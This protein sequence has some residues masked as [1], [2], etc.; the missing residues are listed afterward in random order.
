[1]IFHGKTFTSKVSL[2]E[3]CAAIAKY[4]FVASPYPVII[5]AEIHCGLAQQDMMVDIMTQVFGDALISAPIDGR[6]KIEVLPSPE[7]LKGRILLKVG[8]RR[9]HWLVGADIRMGHRRRICMS[10]RRLRVLRTETR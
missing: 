4:A 8:V 3:V 1:M 2:R 6:P 5:S 7:D 9:R 10:C